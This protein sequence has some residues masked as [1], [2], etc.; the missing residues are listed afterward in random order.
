MADRPFTFDPDQPLAHTP[1]ETI[2][3]HQAL[4]DYYAMGLSRSLEKLE[5]RYRDLAKQGL[6]PPS[7]KLQR[8]KEWSARYRWQERIGR[9]Q[10][11]ANEGER[12]AQ[13]QQWAERRAVIRDQGWAMA[14]KLLARAEA[15]LEHPLTETV[16]DKPTTTPEGQVIQRVVVK[17]AKWTM[18]DVVRVADTAIEMARL[19]AGMDTEQKKLVI[20][21]LNPDDLAKLSDEELAKLEQQLT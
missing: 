15:M 18:A 14:Q 13:E 20:E 11:I 2:H 3:A 12:Q 4:L 5:S 1:P 8:M 10:F 19:A 21:G 6:M 16:T 17:P 7:V 9:A